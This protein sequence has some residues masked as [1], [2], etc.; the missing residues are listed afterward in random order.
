MYMLKKGFL[1]GL[2]KRLPYDVYLTILTTNV[3]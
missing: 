2:H 1:P 3:E